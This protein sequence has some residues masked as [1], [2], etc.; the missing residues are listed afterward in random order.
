MLMILPPWPCAII[1]RAA[2]CERKNGVER[3]IEITSFQFLAECSTNGSRRMMPALFTRM[4]R[5]PSAFT[6]FATIFGLSFSPFARSAF[7]QRT[8]RPSALI[9]SAVSVMS[10]TSTMAMS[11]PASASPSAYAWPIPRPAP[12]TTATIPSNLN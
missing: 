9:F 1:C 2:A 7:T 11:A 4:S 12:V 10:I 5:R 3:L 8:F 6:T